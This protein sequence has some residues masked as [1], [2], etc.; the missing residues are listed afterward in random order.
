MRIIPRQKVEISSKE[1]KEVWKWIFSK[2]ISDKTAEFEAAF[3]Q[4]IGV[5]HASAVP[6]G[7]TG[8]SIVLDSLDFKDGD[9]VICSAFNYHVIPFIIKSKGLK[10]VFVDIDAR[11]HNINVD[12]IEDKITPRTKCVIATHLSGAACEIER[13]SSICKKYQLILIEDVAHACGG[14]FNGKKLGSF[15]DIA[16]F[17]FGPGKSLTTLRGGMIVTNNPDL[18][19]KVTEI[20][21]STFYSPNWFQRTLFF[22]K[23]LLEVIF[24]RRI[25]FAVIVYPILIVLDALGLDFIERM[26]GDKYTLQDARFEQKLARYTD[27]QA[28]IGLVQLT[29]IDQ[30]NDERIHHATLLTKLLENIDGLQLDPIPV[31][32]ENIVLLFNVAAPRIEKLRRYLLYRGVDAKRTSMKDCVQLLNTSDSC[33][34]VNGMGDRIIE[35]PCCPGFSESDIYYQANLIR[36]FYGKEAVRRRSSQEQLSRC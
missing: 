13:I 19:S 31:N 3:A 36:K 30:R 29:R 2:K 23:P 20:F 25:F 21:K 22:A 18:F 10:P 24:T 16:V 5:D 32:K 34:V 14:E 4:Y 26:S 17:S 11:T 9:E 8:F 15:G 33:P 7:R 1:I 6:S 28:V 27:L 35:L 12:L